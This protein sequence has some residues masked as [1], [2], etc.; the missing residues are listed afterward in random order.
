[1][2]LSARWDEVES[3]STREVRPFVPTSQFL[4]DHLLLLLLPPLLF[5]VVLAFDDDDECGGGEDF[6]NLIENFC[7]EENIFFEFFEW[8]CSSS[9]K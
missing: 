5:V 8:L 6:E 9:L 4:I 1:M 3:S 7:E 2:T